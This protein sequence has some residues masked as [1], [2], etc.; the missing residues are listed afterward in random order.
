MIW[1]QMKTTRW[2][3]LISHWLNK[4]YKKITIYTLNSN[5]SIYLDYRLQIVRHWSRN[6]W[7][8]SDLA[9][10]FFCC[11]CCCCSHRR[12]SSAE[13]RRKTLP[14]VVDAVAPTQSTRRQ[15]V[16]DCHTSRIVGV[17]AHFEN[18]CAAMRHSRWRA[19]DTKIVVAT[20]RTVQVIRLQ[21]DKQINHLNFPHLIW[22]SCHRA[23][24]RNL[25]I[26][27]IGENCG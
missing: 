23:C 8:C 17:S 21:K 12:F 2:G 3:R 25:C 15:T 9:F 11:C 10:A 19:M 20:V 26:N 6:F 27:F 4:C 5:T 22:C 14:F 24:H 13:F 7:F 16:C 18:Y 1:D